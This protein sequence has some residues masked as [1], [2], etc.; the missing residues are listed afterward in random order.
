MN[1]IL[2]AI[3]WTLAFYGLF[4]IIKKIIVISIHTHL[5]S[6]GIYL[7]IGVKNQEEDVEG[8]LRSVI[9]KILYGKEEMIKDIVIT[10]LSSNDRTNE[11]I[12]RLGEEYKCVKVVNWRECKEILDAVDNS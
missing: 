11:I 8:I 5:N 3:I 4:E 2:S 6:N 9:F 10:D 7:I 12:Q 1:V